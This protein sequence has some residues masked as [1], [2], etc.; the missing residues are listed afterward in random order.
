[1]RNRAEPRRN[2][3]KPWAKPKLEAAEPRGT[4]GGTARISRKP[5]AKRPILV[6]A[7]S[8]FKNSKKRSGRL[9]ASLRP[10]LSRILKGGGLGDGLL[11]GAGEGAGGCCGSERVS[12]P[13]VAPYPGQAWHR[14]WPQPASQ[15]A[16]PQPGSE[17]VPHS[18]GLRPPHPPPKKHK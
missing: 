12:H 13:S 3:G 15:H 5:W 14:Q 7:H 4:A 17:P 9:L 6:A 10:T 18:Q 16:L 1:M 11:G 2:R 8:F